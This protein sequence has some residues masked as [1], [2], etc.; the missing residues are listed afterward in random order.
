VA[1]AHVERRPVPLDQGA[2]E[3]EGLALRAGHEELEPLD[4]LD[5][6][7]DLGMEAA[8]NP[9]APVLRA[10]LGTEGRLEVREHALAKRLRLA[11][12]EHA[13]GG[14]AI[15]VDAG[16]VG[17]PGELLSQC[18]GTG[19][20]TEYRPAPAGSGPPESPAAGRGRRRDRG[21]AQTER[22]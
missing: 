9:D 16:A 1:E 17:Q 8:S 14:V 4:A 3:D 20:P 18:R 5:E 13:V 19:H 10:L 7:G 22:W 11:H 2:L 15:E 12:V 6:V 21:G